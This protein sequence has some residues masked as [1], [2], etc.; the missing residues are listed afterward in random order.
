MQYMVTFTINIPQMLA[1]LPYMDPSWVLEYPRSSQP[2]GISS[3]DQLRAEPGLLDSINLPFE[4]RAAA[5]ALQVRGRPEGL[6]GMV[7]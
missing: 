2:L 4:L 7:P 1:S 5:R 6:T 3:T